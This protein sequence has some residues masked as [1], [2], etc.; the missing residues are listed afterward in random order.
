[1]LT[2][3]VLVPSGGLVGGYDIGL[4]PRFENEDPL[5]ARL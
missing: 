2:T 3:E 4:R 1:M 5:F